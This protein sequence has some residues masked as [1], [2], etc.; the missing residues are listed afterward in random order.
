[1]KIFADT[2]KSGT[3]P[4]ASRF[5]V[6]TSDTSN[7]PHSVMSDTAKELKEKL[8]ELKMEQERLE[9]KLSS[10]DDKISAVNKTLELFSD[11]SPPRRDI[12]DL[13]GTE[14]DKQLSEWPEDQSM[15]QKVLYVFREVEEI[16]R[17]GEMDQYIRANSNEHIRDHAAAE[18]MSRLARKEDP[19]LRRSHYEGFSAYFYGLPEWWSESKDDFVEKYKPHQVQEQDS[20]D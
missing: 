15:P 2:R 13:E 12:F 8:S 20:H 9:K 14:I 11:D 5:G 17:P 7:V 16:M 10:I 6:A 19:Q 1:M 3:A 4:F 18:T